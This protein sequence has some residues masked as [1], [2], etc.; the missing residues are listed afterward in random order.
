MDDEVA[1]R[2]E[3]HVARNG[4]HGLAVDFKV[5]QRR[6]ETSGLD[7]G[8]DVAV[9]ERNELGFRLVAI[10]DTGDEART[11]DCARGPLACPGARRGLELHDLGHVRLLSMNDPPGLPPGVNE[12]NGWAGL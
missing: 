5:D 7:V 4:A 6:E 1:H 2:L 10:D 8:E 11:T 3:L 9:G 12:P